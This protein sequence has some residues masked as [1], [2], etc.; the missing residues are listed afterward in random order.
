MGNK[1][2]ETTGDYR[3]QAKRGCRNKLGRPRE[4]REAGKAQIGEQARG[5]VGDHRKPEPSTARIWGQ[6][7]DE[8]DQK[9]EKRRFRNKLGET[10]RDHRRPEPG[11][12]RIREQARDTTGD[13]RGRQST[14][15]GIS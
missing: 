6:V 4:I 3:R 12:A 10:T 2:G 5:P 14:D 11:K 13:K 9:Q 15:W 7:R 1:L 8:G